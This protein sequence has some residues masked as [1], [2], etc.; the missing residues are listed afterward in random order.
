[1]KKGGRGEITGYRGVGRERVEWGGKERR[2]SEKGEI[3]SMKLRGKTPELSLS[4][5]S[6]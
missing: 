4:N 5:V 6:L 3:C 2:G 1:M